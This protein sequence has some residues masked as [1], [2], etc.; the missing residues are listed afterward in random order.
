MINCRAAGPVFYKS[1]SNLCDVSFIK[2]PILIFFNNNILSFNIS[3]KLTEYGH[4]PCLNET[5]QTCVC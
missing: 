2:L 5:I 4:T 1:G 3:V